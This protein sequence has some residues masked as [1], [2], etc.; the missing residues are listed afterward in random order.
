VTESITPRQFEDAK[1]TDDWRVL[2]DPEG[3]EADIAIA[4]GR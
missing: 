2:A 1:S 4:L 3:N